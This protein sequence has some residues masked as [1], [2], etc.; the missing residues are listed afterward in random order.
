MCMLLAER[1]VNPEEQVSSWSFFC[2][3][4]LLYIKLWFNSCFLQEG[5]PVD[6]DEDDD[7]EEE[8]KGKKG[9]SRLQKKYICNIP[10]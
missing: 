3:N 8:E 2:L 10:K 6:E 5:A 1:N 4:Q 9:V 7:D